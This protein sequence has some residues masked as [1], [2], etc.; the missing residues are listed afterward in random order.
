VPIGEEE[1]EHVFH[2]PRRFHLFMLKLMVWRLRAARIKEGS[3]LTR[4]GKPYVL[5]GHQEISYD[6]RRNA[7]LYM[8]MRS[9]AATAG[10]KEVGDV[11]K[12]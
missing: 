1:A 4:G 2:G 9:L 5:R 8:Y 11:T 6:K 12:G 3:F 10:Q 7:Q